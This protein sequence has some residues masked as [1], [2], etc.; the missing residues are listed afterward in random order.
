M[1]AAA[2][3]TEGSAL[4][5]FRS[6][7]DAEPVA[8]TWTRLKPVAE[9]GAVVPGLE[10]PDPQEA[11]WQPLE[12]DDLAGSLGLLREGFDRQPF[13]LWKAP[14]LGRVLAIQPDRRAGVG[15]VELLEGQAASILG[16]HSF[17]VAVATG[18][19]VWAWQDASL[20]WAEAP[21]AHSR[22]SLITPAGA[23]PVGAAAM[24]PPVEWPWP[25]GQPF[26]ENWPP[27]SA[28]T[29]AHWV[30][31][32]NAVRRSIM[33]DIGGD[34]Q[35]QA[36]S[37]ALWDHAFTLGVYMAEERIRR[38]HSGLLAKGERARSSQAVATAAAGASSAAAAKATRSK[39]IRHFQPM[40]TAENERRGSPMNLAEIA[41][42]M[43]SVWP[44]G[45]APDIRFDDGEA[46]SEQ[47]LI[48]KVIPAMKR[49]GLILP[50]AKRGRR[51]KL[52]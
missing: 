23:V 48:A 40:L 38:L 1:P 21:S 47:S 46:Y 16:A 25:Q 24:F 7:A 45:L 27:F 20:Y 5:L 15:D 19:A 13:T 52:R 39:L 41:A 36:M 17:P 28:F 9:V 26:A 44:K 6:S 43:L 34:W 2:P 31:E 49:E 18:R 33:V 11:D 32:A 4:P 22:A 12:D 3:M 10:A 30:W 37:S 51:P 42:F 14:G 50:E 29:W 8:L 35:R